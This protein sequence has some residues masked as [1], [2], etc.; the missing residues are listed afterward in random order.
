MKLNIIN[1]N[2]LS[3]YHVQNNQLVSVIIRFRRELQT[4]NDNFL[5]WFILMGQPLKT[6]DL[7]EIRLEHNS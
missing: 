7:T 1:F 2:Y 5:M 3:H 6:Y 4:I